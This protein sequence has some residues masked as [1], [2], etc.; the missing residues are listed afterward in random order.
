MFMAWAVHLLL[1]TRLYLIFSPSS[2]PP[3]LCSSDSS[4]IL[5][6]PYQLV[7]LPLFWRSRGWSAIDDPCTGNTKKILHFAFCSIGGLHDILLEI[8]HST[9][10]HVDSILL[11]SPRL[12]ARWWDLV[13][14]R[15]STRAILPASLLPIAD[16][17]QH[18]FP[19]CAVCRSC[20]WHI[21]TRYQ[22]S[23]RRQVRW[24][25]K[26]WYDMS[27][28]RREG[29]SYQSICTVEVVSPEW[30]YRFLSS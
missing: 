30:P 4:L 12:T 25:N 17:A 13:Y 14:L 10:L 7:A 15:I 27:G 29:G 26:I 21:S 20:R 8:M 3:L 6:I 18:Q 16:L 9:V 24:G 1:Q 22:Y 19:P 23:E 2:T 28:S 5:W 11:I